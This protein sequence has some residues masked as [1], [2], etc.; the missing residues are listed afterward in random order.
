MKS[1]GVRLPFEAIADELLAIL[2]LDEHVERANPAFQKLHDPLFD[3]AAVAAWRRREIDMSGASGA[4][5]CAH[6][7]QS[8]RLKIKRLIVIPRHRD[9]PQQGFIEGIY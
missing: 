4:C 9:R 6:L 7:L 8:M 1:F 5:F 3:D 2:Y